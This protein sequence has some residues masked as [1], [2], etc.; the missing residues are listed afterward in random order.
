MSERFEIP[1]RIAALVQTL[2]VMDAEEKELKTEEFRPDV[3]AERLHTEWRDA[4]IQSAEE[5]FAWA[6]ALAKTEEA[7][8]FLRISHMP[9]AYGNILFFEDA[10]PGTDWFGLGI[11]PRGL[12]VAYSGRWEFDKPRI[13]LRSPNELAFFV[14]PDALAL[15]VQC[16][17][18]GEA[19]QTIEDGFA[20]LF[21]K[22]GE[23]NRKRALRRSL[24]SAPTKWLN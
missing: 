24:R 20:Y 22:E 3:L 2:R 11:E 8:V 14:H 16:V 17:R 19:W 12:Y 9:T 23:T 4:G 10:A 6:A 7:K 13:I 15:A 5:V 21:G 18:S 1:E